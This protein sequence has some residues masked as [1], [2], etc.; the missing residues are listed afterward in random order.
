M[1]FNF[2]KFDSNYEDSWSFS[3]FYCLAF[4]LYYSTWSFASKSWRCRVH[5][6]VRSSSIYFSAV[7]TLLYNEPFS[8]LSF[9]ISWLILK[10]SVYFYWISSYFLRSSFFKVSNF[11][12]FA[13]FSDRSWWTSRYNSILDILS[14]LI[15]SSALSSFLRFSSR[16]FESSST[17]YLKWRNYLSVLLI[18]SYFLITSRFNYST[19]YSILLG[20]LWGAK[21]TFL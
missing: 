20:F 9:L 11:F 3:C 19:I 10:I 13:L 1:T 21:P 16:F 15:R 4:A 12:S 14:S 6:L 18:S 5:N 2:D 8:C 17:N 7:A